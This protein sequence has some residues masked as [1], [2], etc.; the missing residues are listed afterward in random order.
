MLAGGR[1][2]FG[3]EFRP[4]TLVS[5]L[6]PTRNESRS[7]IGIA[8]FTPS[9]VQM[10]PTY[11]VWW[12]PVSWMHSIAANFAGWS[13]ATSR[14]AVSPTRSCTGVAMQAIVSGISR[15]SRWRRSRRPFSIPTA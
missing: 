15:P 6:K 10:P 9:A 4:V 1:S 7:G 13:S 5:A 14:A 2:S 3:I 11:S 12:P 8:T